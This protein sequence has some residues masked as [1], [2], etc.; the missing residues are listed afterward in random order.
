MDRAA[1]VL[2]WY[3]DFIPGG[4]RVPWRV[5]SPSSSLLP[6]PPFPDRGC[7]TQTMCGCRVDVLLG[8]TG[9]RPRMTAPYP[10][11]TLPPTVD[12]VGPLPFPDSSRACSTRRGPHG[13]S[14]YWRGR[15][16]SSEAVSTK[17]ASPCECRSTPPNCRRSNRPY[18]ST[19][20]TARAHRW[21]KNDTAFSYRDVQLRP[22]RSSASA[23]TPGRRVTSSKSWTVCLTGRRSIRTPLGGAYVNLS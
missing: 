20:S 5:G 2:R 19:R 17:K 9:T 14:S 16:L 4:A 1:G 18:T 3:R 10:A 8:P 12:F 13:T 23:P 11:A 22:G 7:T 15:L 6:G 21:G